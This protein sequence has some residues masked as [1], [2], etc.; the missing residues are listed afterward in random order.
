MTL[1]STYAVSRGLDPPTLISGDTLVPANTLAPEAEISFGELAH[2]LDVLAETTGDDAFS[3]G[4]AEALPARPAGVYQIIIFHSHTLREAVCAMCRFSALMTAAFSMSYEEDGSNGW[5]VFNFPAELAASRQF[6][7]GQLAVIAVRANQL[8]GASCRPSRVDFTFPAPRALNEYRRVLGVDIRFKTHFNRIA[9][10]LPVLHAPL[11]LAN[12][13]LISQLNGYGL[14][15]L[16]LNTPPQTITAR[17][18]NYISGALH[19]GEATELLACSALT[20][21]RRKLQRD[22]LA[23]GTTFRGILEQERMRSAEHYLTHTTLS[24]TAISA[25]LGYS[26][27]SAFSR[28][29]RT[30]FG[31]A[32]SAMR[33]TSRTEKLPHP[34]RLLTATPT[35]TDG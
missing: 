25:L 14:E 34:D 15:L 19:R 23:A 35:P 3:L 5:V 8:L 32:P 29:C 21:G 10:P 22:L 30:W 24:L 11:P 4:F 26:E 20:I 33:R 28:A 1:L 6:V 9:F 17:V 27:L 12:A 31:C 16:A 7:A 13:A 2:A 18:A